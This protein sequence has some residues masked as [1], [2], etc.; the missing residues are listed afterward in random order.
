MAGSGSGSRTGT[1]TYPP[2]CWLC[3][4]SERDQLVASPARFLICAG[5][6]LEPSTPHSTAVDVSKP[7]MHQ[8]PADAEG[9]AHSGRYG[10]LTARW[11]GRVDRG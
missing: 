2:G 9:G 5:R 1:V 4:E 6:K 8:L 3:S 7:S 10:V 11:W